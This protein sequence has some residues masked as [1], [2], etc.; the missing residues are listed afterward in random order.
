MGINAAIGSKGKRSTRQISFAEVAALELADGLLFFDRLGQ[1]ADLGAFLKDVRIVVN[2]KDE[3]GVVLLSELDAF[4][5]DEAGVF[6]RI[7]ASL[8]GVSDGLC[9]VRM[10]SHF[11]A[12]LVGF[13]G[14]GLHFFESVLLGSREIALREHTTGSAD[15]DEI[16]PI[17]HGFAHLLTG[18]PRAIGDAG[19]GEVK[20]RRQQIIVAVASSNPERRPRDVHTGSRDLAGVDSVAEGDIAVS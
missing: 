20:L 7:D 12:E 14:D 3:V 4:V 8:N 9:S 13:F 18:S 1:H 5:I 11:A 19:F 2:V 6:D 16:R 17:F 15:F 10:G